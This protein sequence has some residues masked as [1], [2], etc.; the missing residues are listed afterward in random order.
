M[1]IRLKLTIPIELD[2]LHR[3]S[4]PGGSTLGNMLGT[5]RKVVPSRWM[6]HLF[7]K[8][9]KS[10]SQAQPKAKVTSPT[11]EGSVQEI[12]SDE[13]TESNAKREDSNQ[14]YAKNP[15]EKED[16]AEATSKD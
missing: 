11:L 15:Q 5:F 10:V 16:I 9:T 6:S 8:V 3:S 14:V 2:Y 13:E 7:F 12:T 4:S 1:S